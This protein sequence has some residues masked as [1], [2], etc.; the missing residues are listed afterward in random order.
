MEVWGAGLIVSRVVSV[1]SLRRE[2]LSKGLAGW[3]G[4]GQEHAS[5]T[6]TVERAAGEEGSAQASQSKGLWRK[7]LRY[8]DRKEEEI[9]VW[10]R[11]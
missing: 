6:R 3:G 11:S 4:G 10:S 5:L 9:C 8:C 1:G 2:G 7:H